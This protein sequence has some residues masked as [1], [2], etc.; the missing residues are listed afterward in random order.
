M[1]AS[2]R[3]RPLRH[4]PDIAKHYDIIPNGRLVYAD[5]MFIDGVRLSVSLARIELLSEGPNT[6]MIVTEMGAHFE[7]KDAARGRQPGQDAA[8]A[9]EEGTNFLMDKLGASLG[10]PRP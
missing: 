1:G 7:S 10:F 5:E 9:R 8:R 3:A 4:R 6:R 2:Q